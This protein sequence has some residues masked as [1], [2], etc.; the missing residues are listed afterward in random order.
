M[1]DR[2]LQH[3]EATSL[4]HSNPTQTIRGNY[5]RNSQPRPGERL[6]CVPDG[7]GRN[8]DARGRDLR[9]QTQFL[10]SRAHEGGNES[11]FPGDL[12]G[13]HKAV[14]SRKC[15]KA[16]AEALIQAWGKFNSVSIERD[17]VESAEVEPMP[18]KK[19]SPIAGIII[20]IPISITLWA[21]MFLIAKVIYEA[22][23]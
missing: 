20:A 16:D 1:S 5:D 19:L 8:P 3:E 21:V 11:Q 10:G 14:G 2:N 6:V 9:T 13:A 15:D 4:Q 7:S 22:V 12:L 17:Y 23:R 18:V